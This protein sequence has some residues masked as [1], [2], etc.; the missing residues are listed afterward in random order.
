LFWV[1]DL[2]QKITAPPWATWSPNEGVKLQSERVLRTSSGQ[3]CLLSESTAIIGDQ[4]VVYF[5]SQVLKKLSATKNMPILSRLC[6]ATA[7]I[8]EAPNHFQRL[9]FDAKN[10]KQNKRFK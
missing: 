5:K 10:M 7:G 2:S 4:T 6:I 9:T 3:H 1:D 8:Q